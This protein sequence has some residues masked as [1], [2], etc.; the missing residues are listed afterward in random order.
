MCF[1][2]VG[3]WMLTSTYKVAIRNTLFDELKLLLGPQNSPIIIIDV[4]LKMVQG[5]L[6]YFT[7]IFLNFLLY[8]SHGTDSRK[9]KVETIP[10]LLHSCYHHDLCLLGSVY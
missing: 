1:E 5:V 3:K 6:A 7:V 10:R 8:S 2:K 4:N 9:Y